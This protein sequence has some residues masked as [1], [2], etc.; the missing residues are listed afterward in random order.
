MSVISSAISEECSAVVF[1]GISSDSGTAESFYG[2]V[3]EWFNRLGH[4]P[5]KVAIHGPGHSGRLG[6]F[7]RGNA[8]LQ[9]AGFDG[10]IG[11][12]VNS[13]TPNAITG[14]N[15]F[16]TATYGGDAESLFADVVARSSVAKLSPTSMLPIARTLTQVLKP[17][18]GIGYVRDHRLGPELY[19][20]GICYGGDDVPMGEAYE[21]ARNISRWCDTGMVNQVYRN[22]T[23]R[24]VFPWNFLTRPQLVRDVGGV[25]LEDWIRQDARRGTLNAFCNGLSLWEVA[26]AS[27]PVIR[28]ELRQARVIFNWEQF[29]DK[30]LKQLSP[31]E[32]L[33]MVLD[34]VDLQDVQVLRGD[35]GQEIPTEEVRKIVQKPR[36][37]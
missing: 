14:H 22:G 1:Y 9:K 20:L 15:Y 36:R 16:L 8:R 29:A 17:A 5:D 33:R 10:I 25:P 19:A 34:G 3:V 2:T 7:A 21:E 32:S 26:N 4:P 24:D 11:F 35:T 13:S 31:N 28:R 6:S 12:E 30:D 37:V 27:I 18:Y 23:L